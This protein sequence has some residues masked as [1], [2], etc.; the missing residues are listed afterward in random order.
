MRDKI[1]MQSYYVTASAPGSDIRLSAGAATM[2]EFKACIKA[3]GWT[4]D[5]STRQ[6]P[7]QRPK[8]D[9]TFHPPAS[10][11]AGQKFSKRSFR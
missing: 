11:T 4:C 10:C 3:R 1:F 2:Q 9:T 6:Y 5:I 8:V 7:G